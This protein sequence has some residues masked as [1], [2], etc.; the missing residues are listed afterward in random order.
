MRGELAEQARH[1][2]QTEEWVLRVASMN[3]KNKLFRQALVDRSVGF[4]V[5]TL[6]TTD[7]SSLVPG[8][9]EQTPNSSGNFSG[10][11]PQ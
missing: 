9:P 7:T 3:G 5:T 10:S 8:E 6:T 2:G 4:N 1:L 11:V